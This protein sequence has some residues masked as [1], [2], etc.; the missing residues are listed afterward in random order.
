MLFPRR[1]W[2]DLKLIFELES[3][4]MIEE[5]SKQKFERMGRVINEEITV[6]ENFENF[7]V[8]APDLNKSSNGHPDVSVYLS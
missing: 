6:F 4:N 7:R 3:I 2:H 8:A 5:Q 1:K